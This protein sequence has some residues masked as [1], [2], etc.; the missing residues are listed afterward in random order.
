MCRDKTV[1]MNYGVQIKTDLKNKQFSLVKGDR[2]LTL[3]IT[4]Y[5]KDVF[6]RDIQIAK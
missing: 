6:K 5:G 2:E 4:L 1:K 3:G